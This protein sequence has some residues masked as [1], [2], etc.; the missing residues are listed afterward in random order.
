MVSLQEIVDG[1]A[2]NFSYTEALAVL[3]PL[4]LFILGIGVYSWFIFK[5]Y[6]F[7]ARREIFPLKFESNKFL[8]GV[9]FV[10]KYI[11]IFPLMTFFW[12]LVL[13]VILSFLSR[14]DSIQTVLLTSMALVGVIRLMAYYNEDLSKDLAKMLPFALLGVFLVDVS[15]FS[16]GDSLEGLKQL[17]SAWKSIVYYLVFIVILE[18]VLRIMYSIVRLFKKRE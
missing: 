6:R 9:W 3:K 1:A 15:F 8:N 2:A 13:T 10:F 14:Q 17:P 7:V 18:F 5:F 16:I 11:V 4:P 12:F